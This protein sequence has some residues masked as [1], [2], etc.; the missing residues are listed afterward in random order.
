MNSIEV[1]GVVKHY[2]GFTL[3]PLDLNVPQGTIVGFV[4]EN[5]A[6]KSTTLRAILGLTRVDAGDIR[7]LGEPAGPE[8]PRVR[9]RI[10]VV[11][12]DLSLPASFTVGHAGE[13]GRRMMQNC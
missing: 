11:F 4:G 3:G 1:S 12:D 13:F 7:L 8:Y 6:G 2:L 5:G 10:G 9:E